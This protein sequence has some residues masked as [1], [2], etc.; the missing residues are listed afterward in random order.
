M[1]PGEF[2]AAHARTGVEGLDDVL[3]GGLTP[4][5]LYL[6]EGKPGSGKTTLA[7]QF[8]MEG[9]RQGE[10]VLYI[11]LSETDEEIR[12]VALTHGW[13]FDGIE[14]RELVPS[15]ESLEPDEQYTM[16][17]PSEVE[18]SD[19]TRKILDDVERIRPARLVFDS[20]SELRLLAGSPLR[21]RRQILALK[22]HFAGRQCT[23][24]LL[25]DLTG[26]GHDLQV[27]SIAHG[28]LLLQQE[29]PEYGKQRRRLSV[30]KY[31][32]QEFR[33]GHHDYIIKRGG[34]HVFPRL[35]AAEHDVAPARSQLTSGL[36]ELDSLLGGGLDRG[37][38]TLITGAAGTGKSSLA[39]LF[40]YAAAE[41][42]ESSTLFIFDESERILTERMR[43][44]GMDL[45][46][47][48]DENRITIRQVDPA[49]WSPGE[50]AQAVGSAVN[51]NQSSLVVVDSLNGYLHS[52]PHERFLIIHL[53]EILT[54]LG[55]R[56]VATILINAQLGLIGQV[57]SEIDASYLA[58]SVILTRYFELDGE[59]RTAV[60]VV[61]KRSG[62]HER[63][64]REL[65]LREGRITVGQPL[66][67]YRGVLTG[68]PSPVFN[69]AAPSA[70]SSPAPMQVP[71]GE[72]DL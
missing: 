54:Y 70:A 50:F 18:L 45:Q 69:N 65:K 60:S 37:A 12:A 16:F 56:G 10:R 11:T 34:I 32:G 8:L 63:T 9:V 20:L 23:V 17:H 57:R 71:G 52:M 67:A 19:T 58:D 48:I 55:R 29:M 22:H 28:V 35:V 59:V 53:H 68:V 38:S 6:L 31:R 1:P 15:Q 72:V 39:G 27:Q 21:Y 43:S 2:A 14:V 44:L 24:M 49:E 3:G 41:R 25:D 13:S 64:I 30:L 36:D 7:F 40:A 47:H 51:Q 66:R 62:E 5:R 4:N 42:G 61:K 26:D 46:R 33:G